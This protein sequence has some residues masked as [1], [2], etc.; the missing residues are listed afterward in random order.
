MEKWAECIRAAAIEECREKAKQ[1]GEWG[2]ADVLTRL[3]PPPPSGRFVADE[4][5][6]QARTAIEHLA[7]GLD[8]DDFPTAQARY[9]AQLKISEDALKALFPDWTAPR[10]DIALAALNAEKQR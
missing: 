5:L 4:V 1:M 2:F 8:P 9:A 7:F 3:T 6:E 10:L